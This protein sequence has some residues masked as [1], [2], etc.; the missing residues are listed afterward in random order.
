MLSLL[1]F[2]YSGIAFVLCIKCHGHA[3]RQLAWPWIGV[4]NFKTVAGPGSSEPRHGGIP[5]R[6]A[7]TSCG[8]CSLLSGRDRYRR[9]SF[10]CSDSW[11]D[12][13]VSG[14]PYSQIECR[15]KDDLGSRTAAYRSDEASKAHQDIHK[16]PYAP[17]LASRLREKIRNPS[18]QYP[19]AKDSNR[20]SARG[21]SC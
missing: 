6:P 8:R 16:L 1:A 7:P 21:L 10:R 15:D 18:Q 9:M 5:C 3:Q 11:P 12:L 4:D 2:R 13:A 20:Y 17:A 19:R 14:Q